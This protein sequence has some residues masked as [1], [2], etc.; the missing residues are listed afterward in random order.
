MKLFV[1]AIEIFSLCL[2]AYFSNWQTALGVC[3]FVV[4]HNIEK[5]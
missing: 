4:S 3:L 5:H 1:L 2:I